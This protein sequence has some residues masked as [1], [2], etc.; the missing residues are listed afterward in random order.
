MDIPTWLIEILRQFPMVAVIGFA[1]WYAEKRVSQKEIRLETRYDKN[2]S[3][4]AQ[5]E[6]KFR[7]EARHDR[8]AEIK[9]FQEAQKAVQEANEKLLAAKDEQIASLT[10]EV[11]KLSKRVD[12]LLKQ[13]GGN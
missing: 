12:E 8:D 13:L 4:A 5:R 2:V 10:K 1:V 3:D 11:A 7:A 9:R 6:D